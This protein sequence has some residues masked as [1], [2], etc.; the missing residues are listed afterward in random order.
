MTRFKKA[1]G[2]VLVL[3]LPACTDLPLKS[4]EQYK[5]SANKS[6]AALKTWSFEGRLAVND[7][8]ESWSASL[9][10]THT[11]ARDEIR[12]SGPLGQGAAVIVLTQDLVTI[13]K[14]DGQIYQSNQLDEFIQQQLGIAVPVSALRFWVLGIPQPEKP[15]VEIKEGFEQVNW[16]VHYGQMQKVGQAWLPRKMNVEYQDVKLKL[17]IDQWNL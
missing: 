17:V 12:L 15:A 5:I 1:V 10:W 7:G 4:G 9:E 11:E 3:C 13:D 14:G 6:M 16:Q 2:L 8:Q